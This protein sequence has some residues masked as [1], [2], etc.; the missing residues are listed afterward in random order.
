MNQPNPMSMPEPWTLVAEGYAAETQ[1]IFKQYCRAAMASAGF[2]RAEKVLD[3][4]CGPGT[5]S[6]LI[7]D[8]T[9]EVHS[10]DFS[11]GML[12]RF[13]REIARRGIRNIA[14]YTMDGEQLEFADNSFDWAFSIFGLMFF[15]NRC[16][17]FRE[18]LRTLR[19]GGRAVVTSWAS[20]EHSTT[21]QAI[22]GGLQAAFPSSP[23]GE[24]DKQVSLEDPGQF[25]YEM[26]YAG[27][28]DVSVTPFDGIWPVS[29]AETFL[30]SMVRGSASLTLLRSQL[31]GEV[32]EAKRAIILRALV[33]KLPPL[34]TNLSSRAWIGV[35]TKP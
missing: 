15:P 34:P 2:H 35:G 27:F 18:I 14:T 22:V 30:D 6:L 17:G 7:H 33:E 3:V 20:I 5:L 28:V 31:E 10:I 25:R 16:R 21:M 12:E 8:K 13:D 9:S 11:P 23:D 1:P 32:W 24:H 29:D 19:P 4:A 26:E